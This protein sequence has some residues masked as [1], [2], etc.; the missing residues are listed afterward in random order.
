MAQK[1]EIN[2]VIVVDDE[3]SICTALTTFLRSRDYDCRSATDPVESLALLEQS[4]GELLISDIKMKG[5]NGIQLLKEVAKIDPGVDTIIMTGYTKDY[6]Y[7]DI[8]KAGATDFIAKPFQNQELMAKIER[9]DRERRMRRKLR[10][11]NGALRLREKELVL[12]AQELEKTNVALGVLLNRREQDKKELI[13]NIFVNIEELILPLIEKFET[14]RLNEIQKIYLKILRSSLLEISSPFKRKLSS[15]YSTLSP[16][17]TQVANLIKA[18]TG[19]KQIAEI[20]GISV[21][22]VMTHRYH[23]RTKL[24][25]K[26]RNVN[27]TSHLASFEN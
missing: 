18:G 9:I 22:T 19:N 26:G 12:K 11:M 25:V 15:K 2:R 21:N 27:L 1:R 20:L 8:I 6:N 14:S 13:E 3:Q 7:V 17:E 24:G 16:T 10:E 5:I 4:R 23:L